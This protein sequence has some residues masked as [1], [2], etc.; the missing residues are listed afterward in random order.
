MNRW[1]LT[2]LGIA[3][4][5]ASAAFAINPSEFVQ[6]KTTP[7]TVTTQ[8]SQAK[9]IPRETR[10]RATGTVKE[11][12]ANFLRIERTVTAEPMDFYLEKPLDKITVG[13]KVNVSYIRKEDKN[14]AVRVSKVV[15]KKKVSTPRIGAP[16]IPPA[17]VPAK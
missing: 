2:I 11:M 16:S 3:F 12:T 6:N 9:S 14:M 4:L 13:D 5:S 15:P 8:P 1:M 10:M 7:A 17:P